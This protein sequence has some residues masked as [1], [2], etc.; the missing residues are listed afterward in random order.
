[1]D[2]NT[3]QRVRLTLTNYLEENKCRKTPERYAI[4]DAIYNMNGHFTLEELSAKM[5]QEAFRVSRAT[6]YNAIHLFIKLRLVVRHNFQ[7]GTRYEASFH[8]DN[9][10]HQVCTI[11]GKV[12]EVQAAQVAQQVEAL[13]IKRF[14]QTGFALYVYGVC[15]SCQAKLN[16]AKAKNAKTKIKNIPKNEQRKS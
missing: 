2:D 9:H 3:L 10:C 7:Q 6:L 1:M 12:K 15:S 16:R 8:N 5:E 14:H 4:L 11:C 13:K